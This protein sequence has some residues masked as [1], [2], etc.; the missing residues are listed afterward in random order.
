MG[1]L[2]PTNIIAQIPLVHGLYHVIAPSNP[3]IL[4]LADTTTKKMSISELH[5]KM[6]HINHDDLWKM[7]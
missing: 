4:A 6:G 7:V 2:K 1:Y 3:H 5:Q